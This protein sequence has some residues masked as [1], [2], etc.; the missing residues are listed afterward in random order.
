VRLAVA[1]F[2]HGHRGFVAVQHP[3]LE[4]LGL[5]GIDQR[6]QARAAGANPLRQ[7]GSRNRQT[8]PAEDVLLPVQGL[9]IGVLGHQNLRQ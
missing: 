4:Y 2:E 8:G 6:L 1:R 7:G 9:V 3:V 5:E